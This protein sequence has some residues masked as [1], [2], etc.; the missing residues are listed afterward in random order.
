M[1]QN[2]VTF[3]DL[4]NF[5]TLVILVVIMTEFTKNFWDKLS[6]KKIRTEAIVFLYSL[7]LVFTNALANYSFGI[8]FKEVL[9]NI[10][11]N[12]VNAIVISYSASASYSK[13][14]SNYDKRKEENSENFLVANGTEKSNEALV[15]NK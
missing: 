12:I 10:A 4:K 13:I 11:I 5:A 9:L 14:I 2:F 6:R 8:Y 1:I 7:F 15:E 3:E